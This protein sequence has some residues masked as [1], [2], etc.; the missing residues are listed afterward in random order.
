MLKITNWFSNPSKYSFP[1]KNLQQQKNSS[2]SHQR[3]VQEKK[4]RK[5]IIDK[6][7]VSIEGSTVSC[8]GSLE[9]FLRYDAMIFL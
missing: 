8:R 7:K 1:S 4:E 9:V 5:N 2:I 3:I 6:V